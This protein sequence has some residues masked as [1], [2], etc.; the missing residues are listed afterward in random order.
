LEAWLDTITFGFVVA[1]RVRLPVTHGNHPSRGK[2]K[3]PKNG[4]ALAET[5]F[6][7]SRNTE[8]DIM[9]ASSRMTTT[10]TPTGA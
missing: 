9:H 2:R 3:N 1:A 8:R 6:G 5:A 7:R 10:A 4:S